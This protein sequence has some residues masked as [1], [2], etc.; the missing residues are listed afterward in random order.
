[1]EPP[2]VPDTSKAIVFLFIGFSNTDIEIGGGN[3]DVWDK[4]DD[5][6]N[7]DPANHLNGHLFGQPCS[8]LCE[9]LN[10]PDGA[11]AFNQVTIPSPNGDG[12]TQK[13]LLNQVYPDTNPLHWLVGPH[14]VVFNGALGQQ[15]L[16]KWDPTPVG[17]YYSVGQLRI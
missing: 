4:T 13:S 9:N 17:Y 3:A 16:A 14:V 1:M 10:N 12:Y 6:L 5:S 8:T 15:T 11:T 7:E 2:A